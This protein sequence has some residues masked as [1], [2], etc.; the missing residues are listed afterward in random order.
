MGLNYF[1]PLCMCLWVGTYVCVAGWG[2][3]GWGVSYNEMMVVISKEQHLRSEKGV[4]FQMHRDESALRFL[5]MGSIDHTS[6]TQLL[7]SSTYDLIVTM[8][9]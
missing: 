7:Y 4:C 1:L 3:V 9:R 5:W 8:P 2:M 6:V